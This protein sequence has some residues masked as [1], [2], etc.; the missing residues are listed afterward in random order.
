MAFLAE[1][2]GAVLDGATGELLEYRH[3]LKNPAYR[4][5]WGGAY[6]KEVGRLAQG[7]DGV[8]DGTDTI[9]FISKSDVPPDRWRDVT[10]ARIVCNFRP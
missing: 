2:A 6:G 10:Y 5:V 8:V 1:I 7:L 9:D 3:L 4:E